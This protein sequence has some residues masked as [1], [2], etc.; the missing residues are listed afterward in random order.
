MV[1]TATPSAPDGRYVTLQGTV[2]EVIDAMEAKNAQGFK[3]FAI[4]SNTGAGEAWA[5][6]RATFD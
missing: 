4:L 3:G 6:Y 5:I 2:Q 1:V